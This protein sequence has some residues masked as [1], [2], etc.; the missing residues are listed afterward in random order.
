MKMIEN[1]P[2]KDF[3]MAI[4]DTLT[5]LSQRSIVDIPQQVN[6]LNI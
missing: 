2:T 1:Y 6:L 3:M 5:H 4:I